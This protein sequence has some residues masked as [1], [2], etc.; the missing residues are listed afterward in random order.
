MGFA[1]ATVDPVSL[2]VSSILRTDDAAA[3]TIG[4][5][6]ATGALQ[7]GDEVW[8]GSFTGTRVARFQ[9]GVV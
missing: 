7:V 3:A 2:T 8:V 9:T 1:V 4:F 5:G 6:G